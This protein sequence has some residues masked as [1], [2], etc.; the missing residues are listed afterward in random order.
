[1]GFLSQHSQK[2]ST[3]FQ[4]FTNKPTFKLIKKHTF[5]TLIYLG[6]HIFLNKFGFTYSFSQ[7]IRIWGQKLQNLRARRGKTWK[8]NVK[9]QFS[10]YSFSKFD[11]FRFEPR[12]KGVW[13]VHPCPGQVGSHR[14][15]T[16]S[17]GLIGFQMFL[18]A[19]ALSI[20]T[21]YIYIHPTRRIF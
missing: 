7:G 17:V 13:R 18:G 4:C 12:V 2:P 3:G 6:F 8:T 5:F 11:F 19:T 16:G 14:S 20:H 15:F 1:M 21:L 10:I 9:L